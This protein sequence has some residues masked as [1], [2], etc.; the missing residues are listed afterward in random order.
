MSACYTCD[1]GRLRCPRDEGKPG[2][3]FQT[4]AENAALHEALD[5][6]EYMPSESGW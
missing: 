3:S 1:S 6:D 5:P 2:C 4:E